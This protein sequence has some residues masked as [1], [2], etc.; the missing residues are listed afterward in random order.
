MSEAVALIRRIRAATAAGPVTKYRSDPRQAAVERAVKTA[1]M[2]LLAR[3]QTVA[4]VVAALTDAVAGE[5]PADVTP[6]ET[7][8]AVRQSRREK[9]VAELIRLEQEGRGR[10]AA[11]L[12]ARKFASDPLDPIEVESLARKL[13]RW[14]REKNGHC[15]VA[16]PQTT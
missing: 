7:V 16:A 14:R 5:M 6:R 10:P 11:M 4:E 15:P 12:V 9:M 2:A 13:R 3:D 1:A 8:A